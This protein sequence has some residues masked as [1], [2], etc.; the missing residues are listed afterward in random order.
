[1]GD[2]VRRVL[3]IMVVLTIVVVGCKSPDTQAVQG[4]VLMVAGTVWVESGSEKQTVTEGMILQKNDIIATGDDGV[5]VFSI[6]QGLADIEL[7]Q[8]AR[9]SLKDYSVEDRQLSLEKG[10]LWVRVNRK[11]EKGDFNLK[12]PTTVAAVRGT[13]FYTFNMGEMKG[14][15]ICQ[16]KV[17]YTAQDTQFHEDH[18]QDYVILTGNGKTLAFTA[19]E[20]IAMGLPRANEHN[21]SAIEESPLGEKECA[22]TPQQQ[23]VLME[24]LRKK[25]EE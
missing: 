2:S 20:M 24:N 16:G 22:M 12:T 4:K 3:Y 10:N 13:K 15:C 7:Q 5:V 9:F 11:I 17:N 8:N 21:H 6:D 23:K 1:M 18:G 19:E 14:I 25:F